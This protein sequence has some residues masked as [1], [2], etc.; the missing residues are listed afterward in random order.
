MLCTASTASSG[1]MGKGP[2]PTYLPVFPFTF[3]FQ[4]FLYDA[5]L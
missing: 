2:D 4:F 3:F 5:D 1:S